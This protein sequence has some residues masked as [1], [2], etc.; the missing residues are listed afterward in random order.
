MEIRTKVKGKDSIDVALTLDS[1][2]TAYNSLGQYEK[3][4]ES[5]QGGLEINTKVKGKESI[6]VAETLYLM[7]F[8]YEKMGK[9]QEA[10][11][12]VSESYEIRKKVLGEG[13]KKTKLCFSRIEELSKVTSWLIE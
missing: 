6:N 10:L 3:A 8:T 2:G 11:S 5:Y 12:A 4:L 13:N 9:V 1:I 7:S